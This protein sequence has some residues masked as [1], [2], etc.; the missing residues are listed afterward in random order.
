MTK[1]R[2]K[3]LLAFILVSLIPLVVLGGYGL[4]SISDSLETGSI[5]K[6]NDK[7]S[8]LSF[9]T[10]DFLKNV[11]NDLFYLR[12]SVTLRSLVEN[13]EKQDEELTAN[14]KKNLEKD[15]LAFSKHK[16][17]YYQVRYLN[18]DGMEVVRVDRNRGE[19]VVVPEN[20]L[21]SKKKRYYFAD[22]AKLTNGQLMI[23]PLDLNREHGKVERPLRPVIR[24]GTPIYNNE[25]E[26][27]G[28]VLFNVNAENFLDLIRN[29]KSST[30][31]QLL[32]IDKNGFYYSN[33]NKAKEWG[34]Q[35]DLDTGS[36]FNQDYK[37]IAD[38]I[39]GSK[40]AVTVT[41]GDYIIGSS[42]VFLDK[43]KTLMLGTIVDVAK[44]TDVLSS[45]VKFR[46]IFLLIGVL[47]F[48]VTLFLALGLAKSITN[49][50][51]YLTDATLRMSKGKLD[52]SISVTTKDETKL[53]AESI[54][55]LRRS[56]IILLKRRK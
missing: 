10:E 11:S 41:E 9:E 29:K 27:E 5:G 20:K 33:P 51:I 1:I 31:D 39:V 18:A 6:L 16:K 56:M 44:T 26:L 49:P 43:G 54:E 45:V 24:Y 38:Q 47:V 32:F 46:N 30:S 48:L 7:V 35:S 34:S 13:F 52:D 36:N 50:L 2:N 42:P 4:T 22:T 40:E 55:R 53:L 14:N 8:L 12:D 17:I 15:F 25:N 3:L 23:S 21:Q 37:D 28:I 19:S